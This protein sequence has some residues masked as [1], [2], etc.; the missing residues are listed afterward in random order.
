MI[1]RRS[2]IAAALG[3]LVSLAGRSAS[4]QVQTVH[5][6]SQ[7]V[8][9]SDVWID[10][11]A[12]GAQNVYDSSGNLIAQ[13]VGNDLQVVSTGTVHAGQ[14]AAG[15]QTVVGSPNYGC[16]PGTYGFTR[17]GCLEFCN[18]DGEVQRFCCQT[19]ARCRGKC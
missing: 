9:T 13:S 1:T 4:A 11:D 14:R 3:G 2:S 8:S 6:G 15:S 19:K 16:T 10:Q 17:D 18:C 5:N 12:A 7:I